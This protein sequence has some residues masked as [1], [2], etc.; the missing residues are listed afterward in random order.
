MSYP[1]LPVG[2]L[3]QMIAERLACVYQAPTLLSLPWGQT[4]FLSHCHLVV[5]GSLGFCVSN[6]SCDDPRVEVATDLCSQCLGH[7]RCHCHRLY[8]LWK[9]GPQHW[10]ILLSCHPLYALW[11]QGPQN[12]S[13]ILLSCTH[14]L[15]LYR[16]DGAIVKAHEV[17]ASSPMGK[18]SPPRTLFL[19][20]SRL[21]HGDR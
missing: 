1:F 10:S 2:S 3:N 6:W 16:R 17:S 18:I 7:H 14:H 19:G 5:Q 21:C 13:I 8:A 9:E 11:R 15:S 20:D 4:Q 12:W